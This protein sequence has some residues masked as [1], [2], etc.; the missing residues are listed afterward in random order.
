MFIQHIGAT[1]VYNISDGDESFIS[2]VEFT[3]YGFTGS[4]IPQTIQ[5]TDGPIPSTITLTA[6]N[7]AYVNANAGAVVAAGTAITA[8]GRY[9][10]DT[11]GAKLVLNVTDAGDNDFFIMGK[12]L[13]GTAAGAAPGGSGGGGSGDIVAVKVQDPTGTYTLPTGDAAGRSIFTTTQGQVVAGATA[14]G[15]APLIGGMIDGSGNAQNLPSLLGSATPT[16]TAQPMLGTYAQMAAVSS[17][18]IVRGIVTATGF[19]AG[20][21]GA[22][23]PVVVEARASGVATYEQVYNNINVS[24]LASAART[25]TQTSADQ[26][27]YNHRGIKITIDVTVGSG[28]SLVVTL[29]NKDSVSGKFVN[30][31]TGAAI[32]GI[33]TVVY[34]VFP[35]ATAVTNLTVND[36]IAR[37]FR[38]VV[39]AGNATSATYSVGYSLLV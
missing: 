14:A 3:V 24:V 19:T 8:D 25:T 27:N 23:S 15:I 36:I 30:V 7:T 10:V 20:G 34:T 13:A 22:T 9:L 11:S 18:N 17:G 16:S 33:S 32:T 35:G 38:I 31:I 39:T 4:M 26:T 21:S 2:C 6:F 1:G 5:Q 12:P 28:L 37:L 29:D